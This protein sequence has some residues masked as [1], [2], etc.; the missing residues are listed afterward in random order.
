MRHNWIAYDE[1]DEEDQEDDEELKS[2]N[3][4]TTPNLNRIQEWFAESEKSPP[5]PPDVES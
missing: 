1:G 5:E 3:S 2:N 4:D